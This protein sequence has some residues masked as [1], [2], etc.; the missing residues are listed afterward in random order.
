MYCWD[1]RVRVQKLHLSL[2]PVGAIGLKA[3]CPLFAE[4][5]GLLYPGDQNHTSRHRW[6]NICCICVFIIVLHLCFH[7]FGQFGCQSSPFSIFL[8]LGHIAVHCWYSEVLCLA[9]WSAWLNC[10]P[11]SSSCSRKE[12]NEHEWTYMAI[13]FLVNVP[14]PVASFGVLPWQQSSLLLGTS[15]FL[16]HHA[17]KTLEK[18]S[19]QI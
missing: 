12:R 17:G 11:I 18:Y 3:T 5:T 8:R 2:L 10:Q 1:S 15:Q 13:V 7:H 6:Q 9:F 4:Q 14:P 19:K 16:L